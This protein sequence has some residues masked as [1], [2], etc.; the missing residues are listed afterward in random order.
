MF[1]RNFTKKLKLYPKYTKETWYFITGDETWVLVYYI[2][3]KRSNGNLGVKE[4]KTSLH[5]LKFT[6]HGK[7]LIILWYAIFLW[8]SRLCHANSC[9][10]GQNF[11]KMLLLENWRYMYITKAVAPKRVWSTPHTLFSP[12]LS[13]VR[14]HCVPPKLKFHLSEKKNTNC[15]MPLSLQFNRIWWM[16]LMSIEDTKNVSRS[17]LIV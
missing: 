14:L 6:N 5:C 13:P 1:Q 7:G 2:E 11:Y 8:Q 16:S 4:C 12:D 10:K 9:A 17:G 15:E 3:P